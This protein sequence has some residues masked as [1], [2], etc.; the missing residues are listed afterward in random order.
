MFINTPEDEA[1]YPWARAVAGWGKPGMRLRGEDGKGIDT[2][3][4]LRG[5]ASVNVTAAD[6]IFADG[7]Q[8][9]AALFKAAQDGTLKGF[10]LPGTLSLAGRTR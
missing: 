4:Q 10:A 3:P 7:P 2:F 1:R 6:L 8:T 5:V 9:A